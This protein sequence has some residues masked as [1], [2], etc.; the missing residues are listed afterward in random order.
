MIAVLGGAG[1]IGSHM[2]RCL[3]EAGEPC[4]VFDSL[5]GGHRAAVPASVPLIEGDL[6]VR[7][8]LDR[9]FTTHPDIDVVIANFGQIDD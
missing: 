7:A 3:L 4:V 9:L 2:V 6:R 8:D 5:E 1:Y